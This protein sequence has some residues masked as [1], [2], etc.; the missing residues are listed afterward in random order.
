[1]LSKDEI[2]CTARR[3]AKRS[4][5]NHIQNNRDWETGFNMGYRAANI[6]RSIKTRRELYQ[7]LRL[8][9]N[10]RVGGAE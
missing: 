1:M 7:L 5:A 9:Y 10:N 2:K 6:T 3:F 4:S 8:V